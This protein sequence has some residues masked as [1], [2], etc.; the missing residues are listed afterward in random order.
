M[1]C[2]APP[3]VA[4][5]ARRLAVR[6]VEEVLAGFRD[7]MGGKKGPWLVPADRLAGRLDAKYLRPWQASDLEAVWSSAGASSDQLSNL[8]D[9]V[10]DRVTLAPETEYAFLRITYEGQAERGEARLG[11]EVVYTDLSN[12][13]AG[14]IVVSN[15]SA[16][17]KA[18]CVLPEWAEGLLISREFTVLRPKPESKVDTAYLW[19]VL[20]SAAVVAEW[21]SGA[22]GVGRHRVDWDRLQNQRVPLLKPDDQKK[23]GDYYRQAEEL[24]VKI[25]TL[26]AEA[27]KNLS[28]LELEGEVAVDRLARAKPPK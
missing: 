26:R 17:Y 8:V 7:Y 3:S 18:I 20:R 25:A 19:S 16:V 11:K 13:K 21:L 22:T 24:Q 14:D 23:I 5:R 27:L 28:P 1:S 15:I 10:W 6:E 9:S 12:A 4:D 2:C